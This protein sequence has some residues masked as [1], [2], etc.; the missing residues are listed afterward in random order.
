MAKLWRVTVNAPRR[1]DGRF[2]ILRVRPPV[3][4]RNEHGLPPD[5]KKRRSSGTTDKAEADEEGTPGALLQ[6]A[7]LGYD[8]RGW[9]VFRGPEPERPLEVPVGFSPPGPWY[10][11]WWFWGLVVGGATAVGTT[12]LVAAV[13]WPPP[14]LMP[15]R[16]EVTP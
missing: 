15:V 8:S 14:A 4:L 16:Y 12:V 11:R 10:T 13:L 9:E 1:R 6:L 7:A 5:F 3:G 2:W